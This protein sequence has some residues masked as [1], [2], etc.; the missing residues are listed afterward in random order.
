MGK[1]IFNQEEKKKIEDAMQLVIKDMLK[2]WEVISDEID[3][4]K[5][6]LYA[7]LVGTGYSLP[8][9]LFSRDGIKLE[10]YIQPEKD[11]WLYRSEMKQKNSKKKFGFLYKKETEKKDIDY[12]LYYTFVKNYKSSN[13]KF[14]SP[15]RDRIVREVEY[16][17]KSRED[18]RQKVNDV[19]KDYDK[20]ASVEVCF[21]S[22]NQQK[23]EVKYED[24][25]CV[26]LINFNGNTIKIVT[27]GDIKLFD[28]PVGVVKKK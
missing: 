12:I 4:I 23:L 2:L 13:K 25:R 21:N 1:F 27:N 11:L 22:Q 19:L 15:I 8:S 9:L 3:G 18:L 20:S 6:E 5:V 10:Q 26:G 24:G 14:E 16:V 28:K 17:C 7:N